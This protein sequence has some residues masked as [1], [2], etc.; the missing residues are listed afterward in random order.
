[1]VEE[2][3]NICHIYIKSDTLLD[4][5]I[6][7]LRT[8]MRRICKNQ[9]MIRLRESWGKSNLWGAMSQRA[10][11]FIIYLIPFHRAL[12]LYNYASTGLVIKR[13]VRRR[14][15]STTQST[16]TKESI[17]QKKMQRWGCQNHKQNST[18]ISIDAIIWLVI[19]VEMKKA[20]DRSRDLIGL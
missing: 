6:L 9:T 4:V 16:L 3:N 1:M 2:V 15:C 19:V 8:L 12:L 20:W 18:H 17:A 13:G 14:P 11:S 10:P 5:H 7:Y